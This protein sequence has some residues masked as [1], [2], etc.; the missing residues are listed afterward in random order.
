MDNAKKALRTEL[1]GERRLLSSKDWRLRS[2]EIGRQLLSWKKC[3]K[4]GLVHSYCSFRNEV[5]TLSLIGSLL[6]SGRGVCCPLVKNEGMLEHRRISSLADLRPSKLGIPEPAMGSL[7][8]NL[9][10]DLI[11]VPGLA[12]DRRGFRLGYGGGYYDRFLAG[13]DGIRV[14]LCFAFQMMDELPRGPKDQRVDFVLTESGFFG[15]E[16]YGVGN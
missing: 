3:V 13:A 14:G 15:T 5:D 16:G 10:F 4:A 1:L 9:R 12:F 11:L 2:D 8:E 6:A 7:V